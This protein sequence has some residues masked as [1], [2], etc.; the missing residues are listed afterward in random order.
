MYYELEL[1]DKLITLID[2]KNININES[3]LKLCES[4]KTKKDIDYISDNIEFLNEVNY[5]IGLCKNPAAIGLIKEHPDKLTNEYW[6]AFYGY[7]KLN[8]K[9][10]GDGWKYT[11]IPF[12][13]DIFDSL[14]QN[15]NAIEF[16][17]KVV[18]NNDKEEK[19]CKIWE[20]ENIKIKYRK[21]ITFETWNIIK[22]NPNAHHIYEKYGIKN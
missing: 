14:C 9:L 11:F 10:S 18:N 5:W 8:D 16:I 22:L 7:D 4:A 20:F 17:D 6:C 3:L 1:M 19:P 2:L 12:E 13:S 21:N 15:P